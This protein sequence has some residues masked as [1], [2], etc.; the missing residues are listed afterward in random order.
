M[1]PKK[2]KNGKKRAVIGERSAP[3]IRLGDVRLGDIGNWAMDGYRAIRKAF[4]T[5]VKKFDASGSGTPGTTGL[6]A[7]LSL[8]TQGDGFANRDGQ[9][10][11]AIGLEIRTRAAISLNNAGGYDSYRLLVFADT[12][13]QGATPAITDLL[14]SSNALSSFNH[15]TCRQRFVILWDHYCAMSLVGANS[16]RTHVMK[17]ELDIHLRYNGTTGTVADLREGNL[18]ILFLPE[19]NSN[20]SFFSYYS[21]VSYV[22]N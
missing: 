21:R 4:N 22:D 18:F 15:A 11:R 16:C 20:P 19:E 17:D 3:R 6:V 1:P 12:E 9:G 5:E 7:P 14:E 2:K 10:I 13:N 8:V